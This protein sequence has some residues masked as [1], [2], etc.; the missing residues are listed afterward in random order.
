VHPP[1]GTV[2]LSADFRPPLFYSLGCFA[3]HSMNEGRC[4]D[5]CPKD[6]GGELR[7]GRNRFRLL[8]R[9]CVTYLFAAGAK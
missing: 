4:V 1:A 3:R 7:Q 2:R 9:D 5:G 6:F 8:V